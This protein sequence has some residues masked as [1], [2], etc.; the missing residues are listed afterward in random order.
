MGNG[1]AWAIHFHSNDTAV[2]SLH[3]MIFE[4]LSQV[5]SLK[6]HVCIAVDT[7]RKSKTEDMYEDSILLKEKLGLF[8]V[9][10]ASFL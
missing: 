6:G 10:L 9:H 5:D 8:V 7:L 1:S 4:S 2:A 3:R